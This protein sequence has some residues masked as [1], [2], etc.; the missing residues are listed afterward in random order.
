MAVLH[1]KQVWPLREDQFLPMLERAKEVVCVEGNA[2]GQFG[3][4][5]RRETGFRPHRCILRY[6][7]LQLTP[8]YILEALK[9]PASPETARRS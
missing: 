3:K 7:G 5:L 9:K 1:F 4:L 6:D 8:R 2:T